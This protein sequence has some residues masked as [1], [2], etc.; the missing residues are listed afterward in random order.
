[1]QG[2]RVIDIKLTKELLQADYNSLRSMAKIAKKYGVSKKCIMNY[3]NRFGIKRTRKT[4][5]IDEVRSLAASGCSATE[6]GRMLGFTAS[7]ISKAARKN[8]IHIKD[9]YHKGYILTH[10]GYIMVKKPDHPQCDTKGYVRLHRLIMEEAIGRF[11]RPDEVVHHV[12]GNKLNNRLENLR[13]D[14]LANHTRMHHLGKKG[15]GPD[16]KPRRKASRSW[17]LRHS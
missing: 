14:S 17:G 15:R 9:P 8:G 11:L 13:I 3:M 4:V 16:K 1:M 12:D 7:A 6:I 2:R 5:P 10:N